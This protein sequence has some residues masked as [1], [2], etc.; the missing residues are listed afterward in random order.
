MFKTCIISMAALFA[1]LIGSELV[2]ADA[3]ELEHIRQA[4]KSTNARWH[5][6]ETLVS[7]LTL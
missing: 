7:K 2:R 5:A 6:D 1:L 4:I 3:N